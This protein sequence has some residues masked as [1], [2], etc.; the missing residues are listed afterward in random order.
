MATNDFFRH[1]LPALRGLVSAALLYAIL[2]GGALAGEKAGAKDR[3]TTRPINDYN[4][5]IN[6][7]LGMHLTA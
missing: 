3:D 2:Q 5:T 7:E 6:Y 4:I 1:D